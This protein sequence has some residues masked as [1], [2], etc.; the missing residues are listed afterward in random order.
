MTPQQIIERLYNLGHFH[1]PETQQGVAFADLSKLTLND[2]AV[3]EAIKSFQSFMQADLDMYS[4]IHH[5][6]DGVVDG[7]VGPA[8][9]DLLE[10][11]RCGFPDYPVPGQPLSMEGPME[12]NWPTACRGDIKAGR[13]FRSLPGSTEANTHAIWWASCNNWSIALSDVEMF[14][15]AVG[16]ASVRIYADLRAL[17][18]S[19]LA[20]S[21]LANGNCNSR[22]QQ[23][24][25]TR[26]NWSNMAFA[27]TVKTH[28]D[29]HAL[30]FPHN[31]DSNALM[32]PSIHARSQARAGYPNA[33]DLR[34]AASRGYKL[35]GVASIDR[36][37]L[38]IP[39]TEWD[40]PTDPT[41]NPEPG[42]EPNP[43][44]YYFQGSL[45]LFGPDGKVGEFIFVPK[46]RL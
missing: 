1:N 35:S 37:K 21:Y 31:N 44:G 36:D 2:K 19:T 33:T 32:Y 28:E 45:P 3:K 12:S 34:T 14:A 9:D 41:P 38:Y 11:P 40:K 24:Y 26:T 43:T 23:A 22:L 25:N 10:A 42:P 16:D 15:A 27:A 6:H 5:H 29:G 18:G 46:P 39:R 7:E 8:T 30:G 4:E 13:N 17:S 20:W